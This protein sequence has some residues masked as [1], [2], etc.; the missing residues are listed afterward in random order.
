MK[1]ESATLRLL[2]THRKEAIERQR[3]DLEKTIRRR[4]I[5]DGVNRLRAFEASRD[6]RDAESIANAA[7]DRAS[8]TA[9]KCA[10]KLGNCG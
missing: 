6:A 10:R 1:I 5:I 9:L 7:Y 4:R 8:S 2:A 3:A